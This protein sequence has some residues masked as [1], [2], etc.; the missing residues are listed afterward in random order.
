MER[1]APKAH[2]ACCEIAVT[3]VDLI[4]R[5]VSE[6]GTLSGLC[7]ERSLRAL[8]WRCKCGWEPKVPPFQALPSPCLRGGQKGFPAAAASGR[9][10]YCSFAYSAL[11][12]F[13]MGMSGSA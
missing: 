5:L 11:A 1:D 9:R 13:R 3:L 10:G 12:S 2:G 7:R 4:D 8:R 6:A